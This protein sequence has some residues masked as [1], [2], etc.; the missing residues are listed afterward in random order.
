MKSFKLLSLVFH[1]FF[2]QIFRQ[3][4]N[5]LVYCATQTEIICFFAM[6][7][8]CSGLLSSDFIRFFMAENS[9]R[10]LL[11]WTSCP[12]D[13][14]ICSWFYFTFLRKY[15]ENCFFSGIA[16]TC[17]W[18]FTKKNA[19]FLFLA[20]NGKLNGTKKEHTQRDWEWNRQRQRPKQNTNQR[21]TVVECRKKHE[22]IVHV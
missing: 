13:I 5:F 11:H 2:P 1:I 9:V 8:S 6:V 17:K 20:T 4:L 22:A 12:V 16:R 10:M 7:V 3:I 14:Y 18:M 21:K 19:K 15:R